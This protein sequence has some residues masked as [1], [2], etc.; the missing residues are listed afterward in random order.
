MFSAY[1][2]V[3]SYIRNSLD[4]EKAEKLVKIY[5]FYR[6]KEDKH[7]NLLKL[8]ESFFSFFQVLQILLLFVLFNKKEFKVNCTS[9]QK[10]V[11][12]WCSFCLFT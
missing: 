7:Q 9:V 1:G 4:A 12:V 3:F 11:Q 2:V 6:A 10:T 5:L 8:L